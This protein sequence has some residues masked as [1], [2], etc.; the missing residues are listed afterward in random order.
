MLGMVDFA[1]IEFDDPGVRG[2]GSILLF[3]KIDNINLLTRFYVVEGMEEDAILGSDFVKNFVARVDHT[4][5]VI[6]W[7][8]PG[9]ANFTKWLDGPLQL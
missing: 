2:V 4:L 7:K 6:W 1:E 3:F 9:N 8:N 5:N